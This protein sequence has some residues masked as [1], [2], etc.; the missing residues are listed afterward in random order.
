MSSFVL[1]G[2]R[3]FPY[4]E[5]RPAALGADIARAAAFVASMRRWRLLDCYATGEAA[6][7]QPRAV[8]VMRAS[9]PV[10]AATL[11]EQWSKVSGFEVTMWPLRT[12]A[13]GRAA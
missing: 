13:A 3:P 8:L 1:L 9:S 6:A 7:D 11:A 5:V 10:A 12:G 4:Q 2:M